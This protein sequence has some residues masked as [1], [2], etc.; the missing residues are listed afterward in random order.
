MYS[1]NPRRVGIYNSYT[2]TSIHMS[3]IYTN[4]PLQSEL[5]TQRCS[6]LDNEKANTPLR[7]LNNRRSGVQ[8]WTRREY[9]E[10]TKGKY[11][12]QPQLAT[13]YVED[14]AKLR[15]S[16]GGETLGEDVSKLGG[17]LDTEYPNIADCD[18]VAHEVQVNLHMLRLLMLNGV[19][20][21]IHGAD[22][23]A[24][25]ERALGERAVELRQELS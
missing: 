13:C 10:C 7:S 18:T 6:R 24:A 2:W 12:P 22:I 19:G 5:P 25:D 20:G 11:P 1:S 14:G 16:Q 9:K 17:G 3:S 4:T 23:I 15:E 8:D 21:E